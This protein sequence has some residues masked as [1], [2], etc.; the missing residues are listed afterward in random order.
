MVVRTA[1][2]ESRENERRERNEMDHIA[3]TQGQ[4]QIKADEKS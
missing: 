2:R 1:F 4:V 3:G